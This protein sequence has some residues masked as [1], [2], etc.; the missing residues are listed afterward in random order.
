MASYAKAGVMDV[1]TDLAVADWALLIISLVAL[2]GAAGFLAG[3]LGVGG[4]IV[5]VPGLL[6]IFQALGMASES[7]I[8]VC[9]GTSLALIIPNGLMS[10]RAHWKKG[11]VD[12][13]LVKAI[14]IGILGGVVI[15]TVVADILAGPTLQMIFASAV[16][17]LAVLMVAN[18][19]RFK[20]LQAMPP[21]PWP[22]VA[23]AGIGTISTLIGIGGGTLSVPFM[24]LCNIPIHK[25]IGTA[26]ALGVV[27]AVPA[28]FGFVIIG[29]GEDGRPPFS[30]GYVNVLARFLILPSSLMAVKAGV[31]AAHK[32]PVDLMRRV[33]AGFLVLV[34]FKMW[35]DIL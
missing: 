24:S 17:C 14:G 7:L 25:A 13:V 26:A 34:A 18:P 3:L 31:W 32:A 27:I 10:A 21:Q 2:G 28:A 23:G 11:A 20:L 30:A 35:M 29:M 12:F 9:V 8:H 4:G 19:A 22:S 33:F 6:F 5:L 1:F 16:V 15:G